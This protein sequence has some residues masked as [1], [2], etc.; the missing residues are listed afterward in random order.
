[1]E[2]CIPSSEASSWTLPAWLE[3]HQITDTRFARAYNALGDQRRALLKGLIARHYALNPPSGPACSTAIERFDL[4]ER[5]RSVEPVSSVLLLLDQS[6]D[7]PALFLAALMPALCARA[8]QVLVARL[9]RK[10]A[11]S[12][13]L[14]VSC[15]LSGQE[16]LAALGPVL[17]QRLL[18]DCAA[19]GEACV[20]VHPDTAEFRRLLSQ[21]SLREALDASAM[22][23]V[24]LR[25]PRT[26]GLWR[27]TSLDF[28]P[29][30]VE[31]LYGAL[32]FD[33]AGAIPGQRS[34]MAPDEDAWAA[35]ST[36]QRDLLLVPAARAGQGSAAVSVSG[37]CLGLWRWPEL[38]PGLF[39]RERQVFTSS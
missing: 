37:D 23:F 8:G 5:T 15:E 28:P 11:V 34:R 9:G 12:D 3:P 32:S 33:S 18:L 20:V 14:L 2:S 29:H 7:A 25:A 17:L 30:D 35:F 21:K 4:M 39:V 36:E 6:I 16:R 31:L 24:P 13:A 19:S 1:M 26:S 27:D 10:S 22:R 38:H